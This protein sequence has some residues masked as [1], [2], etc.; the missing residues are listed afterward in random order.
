MTHQRILDVYRTDPFAAGLHEVLGAVD[1]LDEPFV[2]HRGD[3][4]GF[5]P[6]IF[7]PAMSLVGRIIVTGSYPGTTYFELAGSVPVARSLH[8]LALGAFR[9]HHTQFDKGCRPALFC[10]DFILL[11]RGPVAHVALEFADRGKWRRF[12]HPPEVE[13]VEVMF[14]ECAHEALRWRRAPTNETNRPPEFPAAGVFLQSSEHAEPDGGDTARDSD[15]LL[16]DQVEDTFGV[17]IGPR[18]NQAGASHG[19]RIG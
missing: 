11:V 13:D 18:E 19:A 9:A 8:G 17:H 15:V 4:A 12:G 10:A 7:G 2:I 14:V 16:A 5:E 6:S 3:V 1:N